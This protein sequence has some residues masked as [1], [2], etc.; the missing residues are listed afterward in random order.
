MN[1]AQLELTFAHPQ[2]RIHSLRGQ[3]RLARAKWWFSRMQQVVD[4][5][6]EWQPAVFPR[7]EQMSFPD[8]CR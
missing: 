5:A 2:P 7:P 8:T 4:S 3:R 6:F 1:T